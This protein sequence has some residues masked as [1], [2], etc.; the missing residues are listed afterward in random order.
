MAKKLTYRSNNNDFQ[1]EVMTVLNPLVG[2]HPRVKAGMSTDFSAT[3]GG[4]VTL[5]FDVNVYDPTGMH[6]TATAGDEFVI[7][8]PGVY[9]AVGQMGTVSASS[10]ASA[11]IGVTQNGSF[12]NMHHNSGD[13]K[14]IFSMTCLFEAQQGDIIKMLVWI[15]ASTPKTLN[16]S[17][18][19]STKFTL[20]FIDSY[21]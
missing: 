16:H 4:W 2:P 14:S 18:D 19:A 6:N 5:S 11:W 15:D 20:Q 13:P 21:D 10:N 7:N 17:G 12:V 3:V 1:R 8:Y 9:M